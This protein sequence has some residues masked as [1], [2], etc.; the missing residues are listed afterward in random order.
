M[1][2]TEVG[3]RETMALF[4]RKN[5]PTIS[6]IESYYEQQNRRSTSTGR[7][8][9]MAILAIILTV[10]VLALLFFG[11]RWLY[12]SIVDN[13]SAETTQQDVN[14]GTVNIDGFDGENS[15]QSN[16]GNELS[17]GAEN[18]GT[19]SDSAAST[20]ESNVDRIAGSNTNENDDE[21]TSSSVAGSATN[22][23]N[24][25]AGE[26]ALIVSLAAGVIATIA[27]YRRKLN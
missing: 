24:T 27:S 19:V 16:S 15:T 4:K 23:P 1:L 9:V 10:V 18:E 14:S 21:E 8:W 17:E 3:R 2:I 13:D 26:T 25:G 7:A 5:N 6:E 12:N 11:G 20:N 22:I